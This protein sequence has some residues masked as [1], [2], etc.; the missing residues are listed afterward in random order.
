MQK[1]HTDDDMYYN[2]EES[3]WAMY[4]DM[5]NDYVTEHDQKGFEKIGKRDKASEFK[6]AKKN[7]QDDRREARKHKRGEW[8]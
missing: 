7:R 5:G 2:F 4:S 6:Q 3:D 1:L 8:E